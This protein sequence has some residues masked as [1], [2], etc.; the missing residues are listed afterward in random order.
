MVAIIMTSFM[1]FWK[2]GMNK[3]RNFEWEKRVRMGELL[4][5][6]GELPPM[7]GIGEGAFVLGGGPPHSRTPLPKVELT[8]SPSTPQ[9]AAESTSSPTESRVP[10]SDTKSS[11]SADSMAI[12]PAKTSGTG[13]TDTARRRRS[14]QELFLRTSGTPVARLPG[15]SIYYTSA[16]TSHSH[17]PHTFA[18]FLHHFPALHSTCIFLHVRTAAQPHVPAHEKLALEASP[19]W[20]GV[21]RG[22]YRVGYMETP[23]FTAAEFTLYLFEKLGRQVDGLTH[24]LQYTA[25]KARRERGEEGDR[26]GLRGWVRRIP[27]TIRG[28]AIDTAWSG[29]DEVIGGVGKGWKVPV[30]EVV[31]VGAVAEV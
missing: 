10:G 18:H 28:W 4:R 24:V 23:D 29:V 6:E 25:L 3:K 31:S 11:I 7:K 2:W 30:G 12:L 5:R 14:A 8:M 20:D 15:I 17:A 27:E 9:A 19:L 13:S 26:R 21:W 16:P 22:V 1:A